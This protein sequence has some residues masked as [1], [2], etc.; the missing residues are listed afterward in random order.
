V[1]RGERSWTQSQLKEKE[2]NTND[3]RADDAGTLSVG[4]KRRHWAAVLQ[5]AKKRWGEDRVQE[6]AQLLA[7]Y[8]N[9]GSMRVPSWV[10]KDVYPYM[11]RY[12]LWYRMPILAPI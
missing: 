3:R 4:A 11:E 2:T 6:Q 8:H 7:A 10:K 12:A 9:V 1:L 5:E